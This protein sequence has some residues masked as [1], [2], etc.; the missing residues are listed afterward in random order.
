M[1]T[2]EAS[3]K[4]IAFTHAA[5]RA[6]WNIQR[7]KTDEELKALVAKGGVV[8]ACG[9]AHFLAQKEKATLSDFV[10]IIDYLVRLVGIEHVG[11]GM[12][13]TQGQSRQWFQWM[14]R[15]R[16]ID[17]I[18]RLQ[19]GSQEQGQDWLRTRF[20]PN[21]SPIYPK[22][23]VTPADFP[24]LTH[25][26]LQRDYSESDVQKIIGKNFLRLFGEVWR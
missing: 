15:G 20:D 23:F 26:L 2:I 4:P 11:I 10:D 13:F 7:N 6:L 9:Y 5:P 25:A 21:F 18:P 3:T 19:A 17:R 14:V 1:D 12:D 22:G 8:G 16:N 24:N